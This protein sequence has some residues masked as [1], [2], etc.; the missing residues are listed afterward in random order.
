[1]EERRLGSCFNL[2]QWQE[3]NDDRTDKKYQTDKV[4]DYPLLNLTGNISNN[5]KK[6]Q[7]LLELLTWQH[8]LGGGGTANHES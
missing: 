1:M 6:K 2:K 3:G 7:D 4:N 5:H 8:I